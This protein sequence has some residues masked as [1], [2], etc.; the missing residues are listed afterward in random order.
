MFG[1]ESHAPRVSFLLTPLP[2]RVRVA[3]RGKKNTDRFPFSAHILIAPATLA[4]LPIRVRVTTRGTSLPRYSH[5]LH[6][7]AFWGG[8]GI[9][10]HAPFVSIDSPH[11]PIH[12]PHSNPTPI[13]V[14]IT[15]I[16][17]FSVSHAILSMCHTPFFLYIPGISVFL[18]AD[19]TADAVGLTSAAP[20]NGA[21]TP[22]AAA[23]ARAE[24]GDR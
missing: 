17:L 7:C 1:I 6:T 12:S 20:A 21:S 14:H 5:F 2:I 9:K 15:D 3:R 18:Q 23:K 16:K 4:P 8:G 24:A 22:T 19:S 13:F 11:S 10:S